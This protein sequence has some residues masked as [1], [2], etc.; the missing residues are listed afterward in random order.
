MV[1]AHVEVGRHRRGRRLKMPLAI[2]SS[3]AVVALVAGLL[4]VVTRQSSR[5]EQSGAA[6]L[7]LAGNAAPKVTG[8]AGYS[9]SDGRPATGPASTTGS[10]PSIG[11]AQAEPGCPLPGR[12]LTV[13]A[14]PDIGPALRT[15]AA[16]ATTLACSIT[17]VDQDPASFEADRSAGRPGLPDVWI[18]NSSVWSARAARDRILPDARHPSIA[19]SPIVLALT[20]PEAAR[21]K[22]ATGSMDTTGLFTAG[23]AAGVHLGIPDPSVSV[24]SAGALLDVGSAIPDDTDA[25][26]ALAFAVRSTPKEL[27]PSGPALLSRMAAATD[28]AVPVSEHDLWQYNESGPA[29]PAVAMYPSSR[30]EQLDY[31]Y[32]IIGRDAPVTAVADQFLEL[33]STTSARQRL[34]QNGFRDPSGLAGAAGGADPTIRA[35][36]ATPGLAAVD[37]TVR[38]VA[39]VA[40]PSRV[41]AVIDVSGSMAQ[42]VPGGAGKTRLQYAQA[43]ALRGLALYPSDSLIG[44]WAFSRNLTP[45]TDYRE[46]I[47]ISPLVS[48]AGDAQPG[49]RLAA[50]IASL[51]VNPDGGTGLYD[52]ALA[53][54]RRVRAQWDPG[55]V[56]T[57][58]ILSDGQNDDRGSISLARLVATL[59]HEQ[60]PNRPVPVI[61]IAF[62]PDS[63]VRAMT[64]ISAATGGATYIAKNP[65]DIGRIFLDAVGHRLCTGHC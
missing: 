12:T 51:Q 46:I 5:P 52:T 55:R 21:V 61:S 57:V 7:A 44:L 18:P 64:A 23:S 50:A 15:I 41:L 30:I 38:E 45:N 42:Q 19:T 1:N 33:L 28:L 22:A 40:K 24:E 4:L 9:T 53:A 34:L 56:N 13:A 3:I 49:R 31:P 17:V 60:D 6:H 39:V 29:L 62:G 59:E 43:A 36:L 63:D 47:P 11:S 25:H 14:A 20:A 48:A 65:Q 37:D 26:A 27:P 16:S 54:V 10:S 58:L 35:R 8:G 2:V 32:V